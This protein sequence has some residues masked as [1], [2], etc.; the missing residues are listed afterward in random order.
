L[1]PQ[2]GITAR[3]EIFSE[4]SIAAMGGRAPA[5]CYNHCS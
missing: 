5:L 2:S 3:W 4:S 1:F